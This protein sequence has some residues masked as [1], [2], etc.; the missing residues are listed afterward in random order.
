MLEESKPEVTPES[1]VPAAQEHY[2]RGIEFLKSASYCQDEGPYSPAERERLS[3]LAALVIKG[4]FDQVLT[5]LD[6]AVQEF[7]E[8]IRLD[9]QYAAAYIKR[10]DA[11][12][13]LVY[14][15]AA[16]AEPSRL[17]LFYNNRVY[18]EQTAEL[19]RSGIRR[20]MDD[21]TE[22]IRLDPNNAQ[23]Y[24]S[25]ANCYVWAKDFDKAISDM[26]EAIRLDPNAST[27]YQRGLALEKVSRR[28]LFSPTFESQKAEYDEL[29]AKAVAD[30]ARTR[31]LGYGDERIRQDYKQH[32]NPTGTP[33]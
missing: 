29:K 3:H 12:L 33:P 1:R 20:V 4:D 16:N 7:S 30:F 32:I 23:A 17:V 27:Y 22:A 9:P 6:G 14:D 24:L 10:A 11:L 2:E 28:I 31:E 18:S 5:A 26:S 25:R 15:K 8:A 13:G 19:L 21:F